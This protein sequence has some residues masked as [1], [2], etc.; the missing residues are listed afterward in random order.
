M[1]VARS[2]SALSL[3][4]WTALAS[5]LADQ[6]SKYWVSRIYDLAGRGGDVA[7]TSFFNL[8]YAI[9]TGI[10][11]GLLNQGGAL[12]QWLLSGFAILVSLAL[13]VW[14]SRQTSGLKAISIGLIVGGALSN[15][16]DRPIY[17][18]VLDFIQLHAFDFYWY[19][20]NLADAWIVAGVAGLLYESVFENRKK[21]A[22]TA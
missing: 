22:K 14:L 1:S 17:G 16:I 10:S 4:L 3:G 11:Y 9:N 8:R 13:I 15:A 12:G 21:A 18:G 7:V 2:E 19:I 20:F 5:L 6:A